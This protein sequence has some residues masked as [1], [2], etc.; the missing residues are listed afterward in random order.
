MFALKNF[1][2]YGC[3]QKK[4]VVQIF[5]GSA[6][7]MLSNDVYIVYAL[8]AFQISNWPEMKILHLLDMV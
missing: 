3:G 8:E 5:L 4:G 2:S 7:N 1:D 6:S